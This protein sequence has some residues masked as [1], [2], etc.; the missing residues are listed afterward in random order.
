MANRIRNCIT[1]ASHIGLPDN[2]PF[3]D[4]S[5]RPRDLMQHLCTAA[6]TST[7]CQEYIYM[8]WD[9]D[10]GFRSFAEGD[11]YLEVALLTA[12]GYTAEPVLLTM[13]RLVKEGT[14]PPYRM[15]APQG[16]PPSGGSWVSMLCIYYRQGVWP[17]I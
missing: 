15:G 6:L 7:Y 2:S 12:Y 5:I 13:V 4:P 1:I 16:F 17:R 10:R 9:Y 11:A 8:P 3:A 14:L